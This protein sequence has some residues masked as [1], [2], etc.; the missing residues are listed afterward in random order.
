MTCIYTHN[1]I[2]LEQQEKE[3]PA[4][5]NFFL[6]DLSFLKV[7]GLSFLKIIISTGLNA[8]LVGVFLKYW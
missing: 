1:K 4:K 5:A 7:L 8:G 6:P 2:Q 3:L